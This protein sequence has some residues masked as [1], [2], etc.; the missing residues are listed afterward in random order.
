MHACMFLL[1]FFYVVLLFQHNY[2]LFVYGVVLNSKT[3]LTLCTLDNFSCFCCRLL[4]FFNCLFRVSNG[5]NPNCL[6][7]SADDKSHY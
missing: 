7:L 1:S 5:S 2:S 6:Q 3:S 4:I